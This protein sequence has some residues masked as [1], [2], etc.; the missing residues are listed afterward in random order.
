M[1]AVRKVISSDILSKVIALPDS[2]KSKHLEIIVLPLAD[3][4]PSNDKNTKSLKGVLKKYANPELG[5]LEKTA[6]ETVVK[7]KYVNP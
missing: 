1:E 3:N 6:W 7:H 2:F 5:K 4:I